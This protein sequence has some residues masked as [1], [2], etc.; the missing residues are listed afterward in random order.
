MTEA[1]P[2]VDQ[3]AQRREAIR[4]TMIEWFAAY[5]RASGGE[6]HETAGVAWMYTP[7]PG[8]TTA[9]CFPNLHLAAVDSLLDP[10]ITYFR[11][12]RP[13]REVI[14]W[15]FDDGPFSPLGAY[16]LAQGFGVNWQAHWMW[17]DVHEPIAVPV[18]PDG[19][20][21]E[22]EAPGTFYESD[23]VPY[24]SHDKARLTHALMRQTPQQVW[25]LVALDNQ[26]L[27]GRSA[28]FISSKK[29]ACVYDVGVAPSMRRRGVGRA[30]T[31]AALEQ[32]RQQG[33]RHALLN[34]TPMGTP[35]YLHAGFESLGYGQTWIL[36]ESTLEQAPPTSAQIALVLAI[37]AN[38]STAIDTIAMHMNANELDAPLPCMMRPVE[39]AARSGRIA[40]IE[41]LV[42]H[43]AT[44]DVLSALEA[45]WRARVPD[46]LAAR[47]D[48]ANWRTGPEQLTPLHEAVLRDDLELARM[49]L[50]A[51][52]DPSLADAQ[53]NS[54]PLGWARHFGRHELAALIEHVQRQLPS[55]RE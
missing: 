49:L 11:T 21:I 30:L 2:P 35:V 13:S 31:L 38:D 3:L 26:R 39:L 16:L 10:I 14:C 42:A 32:A 18:L 29:F 34:A 27:I 15:S 5:T 55:E 19:V 50:A 54:P 17:R 36:R 9:L 37:L 8:G 6:V 25:S 52:A 33:C 24:Y 46:L 44:L 51:G 1:L 4:T 22:L 12:R 20:R 40:A 45:G 43:G 47:P 41:Q 28:V 53:F 23:D 48:L 7:A